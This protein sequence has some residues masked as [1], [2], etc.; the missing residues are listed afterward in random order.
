MVSNGYIW[1]DAVNVLED[2]RVYPLSEHGSG[3]S[4]IWRGKGSNWLTGGQ[5]SQTNGRSI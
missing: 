5:M 2:G 1:Y 4:G 3:R